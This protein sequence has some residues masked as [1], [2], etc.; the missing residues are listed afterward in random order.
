MQLLGVV[1]ELD[2]GSN[3]LC[4]YVGGIL[5]WPF[6]RRVYSQFFPSHFFPGH[7]F[8]DVSCPTHFFPDPFLLRPISSP[9]ISAPDISSLDISSPEISKIIDYLKKKKV[10]TDHN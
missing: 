5:I 1:C 3:V 4:V 7:F 6:F 8:P 9:D 2:E 10:T